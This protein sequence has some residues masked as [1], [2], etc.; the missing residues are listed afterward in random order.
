MARTP[1]QI[2]HPDM[3]VSIGGTW[4]HYVLD[5]CG[6]SGEAPGILPWVMP[7]GEGE[8]PPERW[9][10]AA[11]H[12]LTG[13][14]N[15]NGYKHTGIDLNLDV[16]PWGDVERMFGL[17]VYAIADGVVTYST[18]NWSGEPMVVIRHEHEGASLWVRYAH[19]LCY[20]EPGHH[21]TAGEDLGEFANWRTGDHLHFDMALDEFTREWLDPNIRWKD[22]VPVLK[23]HHDP[24]IVDAML[25]RGK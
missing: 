9:Y 8:Y 13:A 21:V 3:T 20:L 11:W 2:H 12:D 17:S 22:P 24:A 25:R 15:A 5:D 23:A 10:C 6:Y 19:V 18:I 14:R 7:V 16:S 4:G 1:E